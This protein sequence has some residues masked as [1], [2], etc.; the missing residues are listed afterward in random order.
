MTEMKDPKEQNM[1][2]SRSTKSRCVSTK[3]Q[4]ATQTQPKKTPSKAQLRKLEK[5]WD[6]VT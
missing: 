1:N 5:D 4:S 3:S 6:H 2:S